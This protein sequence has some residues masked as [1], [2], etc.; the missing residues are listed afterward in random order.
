MVLNGFVQPSILCGP[1]YVVSNFGDIEPNVKQVFFSSNSI[2]KSLQILDV[3]HDTSL[4][5]GNSK[6][7]RL[8]IVDEWA[9]TIRKGIDFSTFIQI[10]V[11]I[12]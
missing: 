10:L 2:V 11:N 5:T 3:N 9:K 7:K 4:F 12:F 6:I 8:R 1:G